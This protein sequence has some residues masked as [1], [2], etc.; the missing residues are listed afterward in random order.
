VL[1]A[2]RRCHPVAGGAQ[3]WPPHAGGGVQLRPAAAQHPGRVQTDGLLQVRADLVRGRL[4]QTRPRDL[5]K[6]TAPGRPGGVGAAAGAARRR[7]PRLGRQGRPGGRLAGLDGR[8]QEEKCRQTERLPGGSQRLPH[9]DCSKR[10]EKITILNLKK[11]ESDYQKSQV[12][13]C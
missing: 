10:A 6:G 7:Q 5:P 12:C 13:C 11:P 9:T 8:R 4:L 1:G 2:A 3:G